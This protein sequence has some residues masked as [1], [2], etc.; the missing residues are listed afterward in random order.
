[1]RERTGDCTL[2][3]HKEELEQV[4]ERWHK[5]ADA[6]GYRCSLCSGTINYDEREQYFSTQMCA[7]HAD[8]T[9]K[10]LNISPDL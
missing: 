8:V 1:V 6:E 10:D 3:K 5:K 4:R 2:G 7:Y 9:Q